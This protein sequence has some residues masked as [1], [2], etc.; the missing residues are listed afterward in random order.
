MQSLEYYFP[1][2]IKKNDDESIPYQVDH[3]GNY[4]ILVEMLT[5]QAQI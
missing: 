3:F 2:N 5:V 4:A 1:Q